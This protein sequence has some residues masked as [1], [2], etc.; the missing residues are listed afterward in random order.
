MYNN[1]FV[2]SVYHISISMSTLVQAFLLHAKA[3]LTVLF[4]FGVLSLS[5]SRFCI[6][7]EVFVMENVKMQEDV[8]LLKQCKDPVFYS[9]LRHHTDLCQEVEKH[10]QSW[11]WLTA[12]NAMLT[13]NQWCG[14]QKS[15]T[16][17][18]HNLIIQGFAWPLVACFGMFLVALPYIIAARAKHT[19]AHQHWRTSAMLSSQQKEYPIF[20]PENNMIFHLQDQP[21]AMQHYAH[22]IKQ[23]KRIAYA[24]NQDDQNFSNANNTWYENDT[25]GIPVNRSCYE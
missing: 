12:M 17:H 25:Y 4:M 2:H 16:E 9:N 8:W 15:C 23:C 1:N 3:L 21:H 20:L 7:Y 6:F 19:L 24:V 10:A 11:I 5:I 22:A 14:T 13:R 18:I